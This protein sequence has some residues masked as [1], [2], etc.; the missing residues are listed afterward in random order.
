[1]KHTRTEVIPARTRETTTHHTC[2]ICGRRVEPDSHFDV[3]E[4]RVKHRE[5]YRYPECS[6][7]EITECDLCS[8]CFR[9][10]LRPWLESQ[11]VTFRV[12]EYES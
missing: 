12:E 8:T 7:E 11:G 3:D 4:V 6:R 2:D 1:M 9:T 10:K 5:G